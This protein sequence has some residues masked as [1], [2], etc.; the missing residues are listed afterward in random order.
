MNDI[1]QDMDKKSLRAFVGTRDGSESLNKMH[2][3]YA[4]IFVVQSIIKVNN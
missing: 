2:E 4:A 3:K 1:S